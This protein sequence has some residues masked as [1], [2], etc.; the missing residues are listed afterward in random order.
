M[1]SSPLKLE[2]EVETDIRSRNRGDSF[3]S[4]LIGITKVD[5]EASHSLRFRD[6]FLVLYKVLGF[7]NWELVFNVSC[8]RETR[9]GT[10]ITDKGTE[11]VK[12]D[13]FHLVIEV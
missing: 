10:L 11:A 1:Y 8:G 4:A 12:Y 13:Y 6:R 7:M 5:S 3:G 2:V 9:N